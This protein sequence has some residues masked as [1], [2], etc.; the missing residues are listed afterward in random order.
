MPLR[1]IL[2]GPAYRAGACAADLAGGNDVSATPIRRWT[3]EVIALLAAKPRA[4][5][6]PR[7]RSR[8]AAARSS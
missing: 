4:W 2:F 3:D 7:P 6:A 1:L 5:T 8:N